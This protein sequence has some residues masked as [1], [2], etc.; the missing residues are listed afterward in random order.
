MEFKIKERIEFEVNLEKEQNNRRKVIKFLRNFIKLSSIGNSKSQES[1][2]YLYQ[3][4]GPI[5]KS[6]DSYPILSAKSGNGKIIGACVSELYQSGLLHV[7]LLAV[8][9]KYRRQGIGLSILKKIIDF[10]R[11][12]KIHNIQCLSL[13]SDKESKKFLKKAGFRKVGKLK[14]YIGEKDYYLWE[15]LP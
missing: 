10:A 3:N 9:N 11:K 6:A 8:D 7:N 5:F 13:V 12:H 2:P 15:Y 4:N 1:Y 14:K